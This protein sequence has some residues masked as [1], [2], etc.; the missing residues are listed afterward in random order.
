MLVQQESE[1]ERGGWWIAILI[2]AVIVGAYLAMAGSTT[3]W[4]RDEPRFARATVEMVESGSYLVPSFNG[5]V[6]ADKPIFVYWVMSVAMRL[7]GP[8]ELAFRF[9]GA[10]GTGLTCLLT[11]FIGKRLLCVKAGLWAMPILAS[12]LLM[13]AVGGAATSDAILLPFILAALALFV[14]IRDNKVSPFHIIVMGAA[15]GVG[16]LA[17]G[18]MGLMPV[19]V[20]IAALLLGWKYQLDFGFRFWHLEIALVLE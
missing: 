20:I 18:P 6:W 3:L 9:F 13:R 17:K 14:Q 7:F 8:T 5:E 19:P 15:M 11:F 12:A 10:I 1:H 16:I 4:D 2:A